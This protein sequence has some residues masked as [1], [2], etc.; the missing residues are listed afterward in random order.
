MAHAS[1]LLGQIAASGHKV[2]EVPVT[3][4]YTEYSRAKGQSG[5]NAVNVLFDLCL[6]RLYAAR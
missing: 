6:H 1:E 3:V 4:T 2:H 5:M